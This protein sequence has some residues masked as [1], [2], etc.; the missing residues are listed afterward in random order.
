MNLLLTSC[1][2]EPEAPRIELKENNQLAK[3]RAWFEENKSKLRLPERGSNFRSES[4][5]L[6]L[7][8]FEKEPDWEKFHHYYFPDGREVFEISL[9]NATKYFPTSMLDSFP[10]RNPAEVV[11]QN[12]LFVKHPTQERFDPVIARYYPDN[13]SNEKSFEDM[14]YRSIDY[15]WS[16]RIEMFTYDERHFVGFNIKEGEIIENYTLQIDQGEKRIT[17]A[18]MDVRCT[19]IYIPVGY[20]VCVGGSCHTTIERY[21]AQTSCSGSSGSDSID[22]FSI[23]R[24]EDDTKT[25]ATDGTGGNCSSCEDPTTIP[26]PRRTILNK[27][28]NSCACNIFKQ[29]KKG[30]WMNSIKRQTGLA[31]GVLRLFEN[32]ANFDFIFKNEPRPLGENSNAM[33]SFRRYNSVTGNWEIEII[34]YDEY[35]QNATEL[36]IARTIIHESLH[37]YLQYVEFEK[38]N[39]LGVFNFENYLSNYSVKYGY[40]NNSRNV[41]DH[42][43]MRNYLDGIARSLQEWDMINGV[44]YGVDFEY[45]KSLAWGG[46]TD[47]EKSK[48]VYVESE[49]FKDLIPNSTERQKIKN[50]INNENSGNPNAKGQKCSTSTCGNDSN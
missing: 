29:L 39:E 44:G 43:F 37:A 10:D 48:G 38:I 13:S 30:S 15:D 47:V 14:N 1:V 20:Q 7:P 36:S 42:N 8:F 23:P 16:G 5:E 35:L 25:P 18:N 31:T 24:K 19:T 22:Y 46:L 4:Q 50:I 21:I 49:L 17:T 28:T 41:I 26:A 12:I 27:L 34:L 45:Y 40:P 33:T 3:V 6:I 2:P 32:A 9:E 11:I